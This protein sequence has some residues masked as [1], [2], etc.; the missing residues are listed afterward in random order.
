MD[1][2]EA[3]YGRLVRACKKLRL[4]LDEFFEQAVKAKIERGPAV[5]LPLLLRS[6]RKLVASVRAKNPEQ[7]PQAA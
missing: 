7:I 3:F 6:R 5:K 2:H 4:T 1:F